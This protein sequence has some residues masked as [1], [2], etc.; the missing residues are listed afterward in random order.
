MT[1]S[2]PLLTA[3]ADNVIVPARLE[4]LRFQI[5]RVE[6][7][8]ARASELGHFVKHQPPTPAAHHGDVEGHCRECASRQ[9]FDTRVT[10]EMFEA[11]LDELEKQFATIVKGAEQK[12][13]AELEQA[14]PPKR[15]K[16]SR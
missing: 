11:W 6:W 13:R 5:E 15:K 14:V 1:I 10:M 16:G 8:Y 7:L 3:I 2:D 12:A 4:A 9:T